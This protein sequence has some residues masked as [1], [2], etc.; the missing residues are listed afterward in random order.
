MSEERS[1]LMALP[2]DSITKHNLEE[3]AAKLQR[4]F[5]EDLSKPFPYEDCRKVFVEAGARDEG[6]IPDLDLYWSELAGYCSW[7]KRILDWPEE[8]LLEV[9]QSLEKSFLDRHPQHQKIVS[10]ITESRAPDLYAR[11]AWYENS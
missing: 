1:S 10:L 2:I 7:G 5:K 11:M 3:S 4:I 9:K 6:F 8:K